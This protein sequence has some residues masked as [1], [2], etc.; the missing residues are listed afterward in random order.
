[1]C[2]R[3]S[4]NSI[5]L[6][7]LPNEDGHVEAAADSGKYDAAAVALLQKAAAAAAEVSADPVALQSEVDAQTDALNTAISGLTLDVSLE[8]LQEAV[9]LA[10]EKEE[11]L[12]TPGSWRTLAKELEAARALL[13][14]SG[15]SAQAVEAQTLRLNAALEGLVEKADKTAL[16][17]A[18]DSASALTNDSAY[19]GWDTLQ[20]VLAS[21]KAVLEDADASQAEVDGQLEALNTAVDN[22]AGSVDKSVLKELITQ[23]QALDTAGYTESSIAFFNAAITS[24]QAAMADGSISQNDVDKQIHLLNAAAEALIPEAR[25]DVVYDGVYTI[26]G[27]IWHAAADQASMGNAALQKPMQVIKKGDAV[28][29][30]MEFAPL[31]TNLGTTQFTGYLAV[32]NYFPDWE[33]G[34][35]GYAMPSGET[36]VPADVEEYYEDTYDVYNDPQ[37]GTDANVKGKLYPHYMTMPVTLGDNEIWVQVYV[38]VMEAI[39][40]GSG[41]QYAKLQL[42][43]DSRV[44]ISGTETDK[45]ALKALIGRAAA[46]EQGDASEAVYAALQSAVAAARDAEANLN[47]SQ[48]LVDKTVKALQAAVDAMTKDIVEADKSELKKAIEVADSYLNNVNVTYTETSR[49]LLQQA[50]DAA[51]SVYEKADASQTE[52][53]RCVQAVD[54][55]IQSL[56]IIG[57]DKTALAEALG[58]ASGFLN[59]GEAYTAASLETLR[60]AYGT[61]MEVYEDAS[62]SQEEADAQVRILNYLTG[63]LVK[64]QPVT[65]EKGGLHDLIVTAA[66]MAGRESLYTE[67]SISA[68][69]KAVLEAEAVYDNGDASQ[70][71]VNAQASRLMAAMLN[72]VPKPADSSNNNGGSGNNGSSGNNNNGNNNNGNNNNLSLI[73]I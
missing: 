28:T 19:P 34:D 68:L 3:D 55:A 50:R 48:E 45:N 56:V 66:S 11:G 1:M 37:N 51:Q 4:E 35:S 20:A 57:A 12:Y 40:T 15:V 67:A 21:A 10:G 53:N 44:Q 18:Y 17:A 63:S 13:E 8:A 31:T 46:M 16:Q 62:A 24:A 22:L 64:V 65:V 43:W 7:Y 14:T 6:T 72:L 27:R 5:G 36:P 33:G 70:A 61:A 23:A 54:R 73:H 58:H 2:I 39:N 71:E 9:A 47:V 49:R 32:L 52:V 60:S 41:L 30:R 59:D 26:D 69:K 42:D 29:L 25:E 38:P